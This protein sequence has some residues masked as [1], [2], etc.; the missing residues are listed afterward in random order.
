VV[1]QAVSVAPREVLH[2]EIAFLTPAQGVNSLKCQDSRDIVSHLSH[3]E[4]A[5]ARFNA[6][7]HSFIE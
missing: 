4:R 6:L 2:T 3:G 5:A 1:D 7:G